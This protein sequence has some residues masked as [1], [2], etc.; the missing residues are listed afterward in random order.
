MSEIDN[1]K[2]D[3]FILASLPATY[4]A[5]CAGA[6]RMG[7]NWDRPIDLRLQALRKRG[8]IEF[9]RK[10]RLTIWSTTPNTNL[11]EQG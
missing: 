10:G 6:I 2:V 5:M 9:K 7:G 1:A 8:L 3:E 4:S 11:G